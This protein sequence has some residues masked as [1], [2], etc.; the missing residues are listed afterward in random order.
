ME[1]R[2]AADSSDEISGVV[3]ATTATAPAVEA[4]DQPSCSE[5]GDKVMEREEQEG[6]GNSPDQSDTVQ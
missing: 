2:G 3:V 6:D 5:E 1:P 4:A